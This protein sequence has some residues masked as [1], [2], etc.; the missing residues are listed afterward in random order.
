[1]RPSHLLLVLP[2]TVFWTLVIIGV[3]SGSVGI[4]IAAVVV[5]AA[6]LMGFATAIHR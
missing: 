4:W 2:G 6:T 1:M 3:A 5:G